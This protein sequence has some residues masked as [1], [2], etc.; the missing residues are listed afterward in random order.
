MLC[1]DCLRFEHHLKRCV[2]AAGRHAGS[3]A[4]AQ[5]GNEDGKNSSVSG[6]L[7]LGSREDRVR[8]LKRHR[9]LVEDGKK[10]LLGLL[11]E[12]AELLGYLVK[13]LRQRRAGIVRYR[14]AHPFARTLLDLRQRSQHCYPFA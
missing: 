7:S 13:N 10:L 2:V 6:M 4:L 8:L 11:G 3:A 14:I 5:I 9:H 12:S 1:V